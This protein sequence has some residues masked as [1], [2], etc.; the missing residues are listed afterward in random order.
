MRAWV[1][2]VLD[3][4][5]SGFHA[6]IR[7]SAWAV[8]WARHEWAERHSATSQPGPIIDLVSDHATL[9]EEEKSFYGNK[10]TNTRKGKEKGYN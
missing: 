1:A 4:P 2:K 6:P 5:G 3:P 10:R 7:S 8:R 9:F